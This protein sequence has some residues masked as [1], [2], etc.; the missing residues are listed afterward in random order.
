[1]AVGATTQGYGEGR[2]A[3]FVSNAPGLGGATGAKRQVFWRD[4]FT[5][6]TLL[7]SASAAGVEGNGDSFAPALSADGLTVA[8]ESYASNLVANDTNAV[9]DVFVWSA[10]NR[11]A[12]ALR[13]S[14]GAGGVEANAESYEPALSGDGRVIAFSSGASNLTAGVSGT[15]TIN[16][17]RR[18]LVG[19][20]N[21]LVSVSSSTALSVGGG[22]P[23]LSEDG[24]RLAFYS[25]SDAVAA[26]DSNNL[27][28]IFVYDSTTGLTARVSLPQGGG[29][30]NQGTESASRVVAPAI[31][32][33]GRYVAFATTATNMV[34]GDTNALQD[35]FVVDTQTGTVTRASVSSAGLQGDAD[36]PVGQGERPSLSHDGSWI[37]FSSGATNLG[38]PAG[39]ALM[40]NLLT[41]ET[42]ALSSMSGSSVGPVVLSRG[43]SYGL[44]GAG[45]RLDSRFASS[46]LFARFTGVGRAFWWYD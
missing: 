20:T 12:S 46:G 31:S 42:R 2:F 3:A 1:V 41:G 40:H 22:R 34:A 26:G 17:Y 8:F 24:K 16:V 19:N 13:V 45:D 10:Q 4:R 15:S 37:G 27:W 9:R 14:V 36:S 28:D 5:G 18:D 35:V 29:E 6:E 25:F 11:S 38:A 7:V 21:T 43:A 30:R 23:A 39:N 44:F 32:G 33:D